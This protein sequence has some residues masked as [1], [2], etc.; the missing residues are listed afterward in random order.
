MPGADNAEL[1]DT[2]PAVA[3]LP[4]AF[5]T[6]GFPMSDAK[7]KAGGQ[8]RKRI[9]TSENHEARNWAKKS[10]VTRGDSRSR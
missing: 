10:G 8:D 5:S 6:V 9:N 4:W 2:G 7:S 1:S 3:G